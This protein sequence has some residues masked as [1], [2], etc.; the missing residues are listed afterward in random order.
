MSHFLKQ[1]GSVFFFFSKY[2]SNRHKDG[3]VADYFKQWITAHLALWLKLTEFVG[4]LKINYS[5]AVYAE[6]AK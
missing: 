5:D 6:H 4:W 2:Y 3:F 1:L